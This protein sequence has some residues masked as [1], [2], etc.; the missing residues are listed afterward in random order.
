MNNIEYF[1]KNEAAE[2]GHRWKT[3]ERTFDQEPSGDRCHVHLLWSG[4]PSVK[5]R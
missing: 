1:T 5:F 3:S 4:H 2:Q